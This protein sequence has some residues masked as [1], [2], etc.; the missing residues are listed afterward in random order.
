MASEVKRDLVIGNF[1]QR[2]ERVRGKKRPGMS[3][4]HCKFI[5]LLPCLCCLRHPAGTIHHLKLGTGERGM[6]R[7]SSDRYGVPLCP[8]HHLVVEY[9]GTK[10][11]AALFLKWGYVDVIAL[12]LGLW[13][14]SGN[15]NAMTKLILESKRV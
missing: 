5:R 1:R 4:N 15:I 9:A 6:G 13:N 11:E 3:N 8:E 14:L 7:R 10:N 2:T 12:A